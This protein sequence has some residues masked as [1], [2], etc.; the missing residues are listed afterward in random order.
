MA[1]TR[2]KTF[3]KQYRI[4]F[5][6]CDPAGIVFFPQYLILTNGLVEDWFTQELG[7]DFHDYIGRRRL[8][9]PIVK[10]D[11]EFFLPTR[12]GEVLTMSLEVTRIGC[13]SVSVSIV[14][15]ANGEVR[16]HA[17]QVLV[18]T[19][20]DTGRSIELPADLRE[21]LEIFQAIEECATGSVG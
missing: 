17:N 9:L 1:R 4:R 7:I 19:S 11:C 18:T 15:S 21:R 12:H 6:H 16:L 13:R 20:L 2:K 3:E 10:L 5:A 8:G 14:G